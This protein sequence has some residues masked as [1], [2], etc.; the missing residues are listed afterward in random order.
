[1]IT[2]PPVIRSRTRALALTLCALFLAGCTPADDG[3][4]V[5]DAIYQPPLGA[6]T[7]GVAYMTIESAAADR[8]VGVS[9]PAARAVEIHSTV[10]DGAMASMQLSDTLE[11]PANTP[12]PF[13]PGGRHLMVID[14]QPIENIDSFP[15]TIRLESGRSIDID[16]AIPPSP[17]IG[18]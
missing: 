17:S 4:T 10:F 6:G 1:M 8:V 12:V 2:S 11:L 18:S 3:V 9:S 5:T 15:I 14:P 16:C 13:T 7:V